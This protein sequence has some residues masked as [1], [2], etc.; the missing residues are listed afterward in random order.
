[1]CTCWYTDVF[2]VGGCGILGRHG[3]KAASGQAELAVGWG[4]GTGWSAVDTCW[5]GLQSQSQA[6]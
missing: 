4:S 2:I 3:A 5:D 6:M 1:M